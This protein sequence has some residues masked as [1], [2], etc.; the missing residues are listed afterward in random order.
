M[1]NKG[2][3][4]SGSVIIVAVIA[5]G[6]MGLGITGASLNKTLVPGAQRSA[7]RMAGN[8]DAVCNQIA[9][10]LANNKVIKAY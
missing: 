5:T 6:L 9:P 7:C 1:N 4:L 2:I 3:V 10:K 8:S